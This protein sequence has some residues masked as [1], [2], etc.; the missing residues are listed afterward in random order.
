MKKLIP[1]LVLILTVSCSNDETI[2]EVE[3]IKEVP[4]IKEV[5]VDNTAPNTLLKTENW[6]KS[7]NNGYGSEDAS[8]IL[9]TEIKKV[10]DEGNNYQFFNVYIGNHRHDIQNERYGNENTVILVFFKNNQNQEIRVYESYGQNLRYRDDSVK[11]SNYSFAP[12]FFKN[13]L[14]GSITTPDFLKL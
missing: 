14:I 2:K 13:E 8:S 11:Q 5:I 9:K 6:L 1:F 10:L 3:V 4:V 7:H 12:D